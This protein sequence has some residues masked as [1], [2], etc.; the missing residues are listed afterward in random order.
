M[1]KFLTL[2][3][4]S[5]LL[6]NGLSLFESIQFNLQHSLSAIVGAN[7]VGKSV[8]A[9]M[10]ASEL[11]AHDG[12]LQSNSSVHYVPQQWPHDPMASTL[13]ALGLDKPLAAIKR[14]EAGSI[15][16]QDYELAEP[17]WNWQET[18]HEAMRSIHLSNEVDLTKAISSYSGGEQ[19]RLL[20]LAAILNK[21][22]VFIF[23]EPTNHL[24]QK[25]RSTFLNWVINQTKPVIVVSHDRDLLMHVDAIYELTASK[26]HYHHGNYKVFFNAQK[27]RRASQQ[28]HLNDA[29]KSQ[30]VTAMKVQEAFEKQQQ[31]T[32]KG[33]Q[34][35]TKKNLS[36]L[37]RDFAKENA[38]ASLKG[39]IRRDNQRSLN[40]QDTLINAEQT[41]EWFEPIKFE[42]P[43]SE[44]SPSKRILTLENFQ[45][46]LDGK[47][48]N[49]PY[50]MTL[51]GSQR[52]QLV[53]NNGSGKSLLIKSLID[54][55]PTIQGKQ[56][57]HVPFC[58]L[59]QTFYH[60]DSTATAVE[61]FQQ[62]HPSFNQRDA[63]ER[64]AWLRL[65]NDKANI[66]FGALS[67]GEQL[68][69]ALAIN[70]LG[71]VTPKLLLLDEPTNHLDL[72]SL[73][74]L[75]QALRQ[76]K[77]A[78]II[79]SHDQEFLATLALT[80]QWEVKTGKLNLL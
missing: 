63:Q 2:Q 34:K 79:V 57:I 62:A 24:D 65:R 23:D 60:L 12:Q 32:S 58:H 29:R 40:A 59:D 66:P 77:G 3:N 8:L 9:R 51:I 67:G 78:I 80:H 38:T 16:E 5:F 47:P 4:V 25:G 75:E 14:I 43:D 35:S 36:P 45:V 7:G 52:V 53:G 27:E 44:V 46:M 20:W 56:H 64:L 74:A 68:K 54:Q 22:D 55:W 33:K 13:T 26:L 69:A 11:T 50:T 42:L 1:A 70:L 18:L 49:S 73:Y 10:I 61:L 71:A 28:A 72:D 37:E 17:W 31:R 19:F 30:R 48:I 15:S 6:N 41:K 76:Y 39:Q 21:P